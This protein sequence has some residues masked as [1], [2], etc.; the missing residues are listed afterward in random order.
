M[1]AALCQPDGDA[2]VITPACL[3]DSARRSK[4][5]FVVDHGIVF[6]TAQCVRQP[7]GNINLRLMSMQVYNSQVWMLKLCMYGRRP[8]PAVI[9]AVVLSPA[10]AST[11]LQT[12][13]PSADCVLNPRYAAF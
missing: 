13:G 5:P 8:F 10:P 2:C 12:N 6:V 4:F 9:S 11:L 7:I 1:H 3:C